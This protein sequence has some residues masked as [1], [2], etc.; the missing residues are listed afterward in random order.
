V[1]AL[2]MRIL[3]RHDRRGWRIWLAIA[4]VVP[5]IAFALSAGVRPEKRAQTVGIDE[6]FADMMISHHHRAIEMARAELR[7]GRNEQLRRLAQEIIVT[8]QAEIDVLRRFARVA[9][10]AA[11]PES[12]KAASRSA[13]VQLP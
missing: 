5:V 11:E 9:H 12:S 10:S 3:P 2:K 1:D 6:R 13:V 7:H 8:Q 4:I